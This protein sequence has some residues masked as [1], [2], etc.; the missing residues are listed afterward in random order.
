MKASRKPRTVARSQ[1]GFTLV[2]VTIIL[3]VL[4]IL[5]MIL[6]PQIG[7]FNRLAR[8]VKV[9][10]DLGAICATMKKF[11]DEVM[12]SAVWENPGGGT[13]TPSGIRIGLF[14]GPGEPPADNNDAT[15]HQVNS[16]NDPWSQTATG[17]AV[18]VLNVDTDA[19]GTAST[20]VDFAADRFEHHLMINDPFAD[21]STD[22]FTRYKNVSELASADFFM[23][24][25]GPYFDTFTP[26]PWGTRYLSNVF[27]LHTLTN[28]YE[29]FT[30]AVVCYSAG[31]DQQ[32]STRFNQP[33]DSP[34]NLHGW[35]VGGDDI[36]V[37]LSAGG[38][39]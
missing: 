3:L 20:A 9:M 26:D 17:A 7:N 12:V 39:F 21:T 28:P 29:Y 18:A 6:L 27:G 15:F 34:D 36:A 16:P 8:K 14:H 13:E 37:V 30:G 5:S 11:F 1:A 4:V 32:V 2:E 22:L 19:P 31:P 24:W 38:P 23:S 25:K 33:M 35:Q 10:E